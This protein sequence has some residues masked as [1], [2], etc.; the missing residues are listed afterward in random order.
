VC[1]IGHTNANAEQIDAAV[2]AGASISTH[3]G[4]GSKSVIERLNNHIWV[5]LAEERLKASI[6]SDSFHLPPAVLKV[7]ARTKGP[8]NIILVSDVAPVAGL[9]S[10]YMKWGDISVEVCDDGSVRL[11]GTPYLAGASSSLLLNIANFCRH[12]KITLAQA[13]AMAT[14]HPAKLYSLDVHRFDIHSG[15]LGQFIL[16]DFDKDTY[17]IT[18]R[19]VV[20]PYIQS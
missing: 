16:F 15:S 1:A 6:I 7:F 18:L 11:P 10:G 4:N 12:T 19:Q 14:L 3:L 2:E 8:D 13:I 5:Q 20:S 9:G 17:K